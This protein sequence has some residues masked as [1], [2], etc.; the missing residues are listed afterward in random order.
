MYLVNR[1]SS[2]YYLTLLAFSGE[3]TG[4][5]GGTRENRVT[6]LSL[7]RHAGSEDRYAETDPLL[8]R[9]SV[10][11]LAGEQPRLVHLATALVG[12]PNPR[13]LCDLY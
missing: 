13:L 1:L 9:Q 11:P 7:A 12:A 4:G 3:A 8:P 10:V 5:R 6:F 2:I